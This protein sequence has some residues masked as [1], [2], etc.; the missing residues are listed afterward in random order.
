MFLTSQEKKE[1]FDSVVNEVILFSYKVDDLDLVLNGA[2]REVIR[3]L[4][5]GKETATINLKDFVR[6]ELLQRDVKDF[7]QECAGTFFQE[8]I[9][10]VL[11]DMY[12]TK[13][14]F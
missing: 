11:E 8:K 7:F 6:V 12:P 10:E 14:L 13:N 1:L 3:A 4:L 2:A 5:E 9:S